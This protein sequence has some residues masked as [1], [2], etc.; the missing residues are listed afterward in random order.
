MPSSTEI[1]RYPSGYPR[2]L[3]RFHLPEARARV[4]VEDAELLKRRENKAASYPE[5][6]AGPARDI[7]VQP[8]DTVRGVEIER[9]NLSA[10]AETVGVVRFKL[11]PS[12]D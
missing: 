7:K 2:V 1:L 10:R 12:P 5:L 9:Q 6:Q 8:V 3:T 11:M 4:S